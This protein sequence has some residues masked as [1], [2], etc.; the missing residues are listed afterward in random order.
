[1]TKV[2][3]GTFTGRETWKRVKEV[4]CKPE[5]QP[6][7]S[8]SFK[9]QFESYKNYLRLIGQLKSISSLS[10]AETKVEVI[11]VGHRSQSQDQLFL[12][13]LPGYGTTTFEAL[14]NNLVLNSLVSTTDFSPEKKYNIRLRIPNCCVFEP[15]IHV[16]HHIEQRQHIESLHT[17]THLIP[18]QSW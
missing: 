3:R 15:R 1:V 4:A 10:V 12:V 6:A 7:Y 17:H 16:P 5:L 14:P 8:S 9:K 11:Q 18:P 2:W 13:T